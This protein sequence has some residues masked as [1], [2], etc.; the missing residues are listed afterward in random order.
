MKLRLRFWKKEPTQNEDALD[1]LTMPTEEVKTNKKFKFSKSIE[2]PDIPVSEQEKRQEIEAKFLQTQPKS[3]KGKLKKIFQ[4][5]FLIALCV[6]S[7]V[8]LLNIGDGNNTMPFSEVMKDAKMGWLVW[9]FFGFIVLVAI[10][11][12]RFS[13]LTKLTTKKF[14]PVLNCKVSVIGKY[15]DNVTPL[16]TGGQPFQMYYYNKKGIPAGVASSIPLV[17]YFI[18]MFVTLLISLLLIIFNSKVLG[19]VDSDSAVSTTIHV[20]AY[21]GVVLGALMPTLIILMSVKPKVGKAIVSNLLKLFKKLRIVK[22]Y[23]KSYYKTMKTVNEYRTSLKYV[24]SKKLY[25]AAIAGLTVLEYIA[26]GT[27]PFFVCVALGGIPPSASVWFTIVTLY[28]FVTNAVSFIP[29]P[30]NSGFAE[31]SFFLVFAGLSMTG[32][33]LFWIVLFWRIITY[34]LYILIGMLI[35][36]YDFVANTIREKII[37]RK[38]LQ[39]TKD[40]I[41]P[42]LNSWDYNQRIA[43]LNVL[44]N[45]E[46][47]DKWFTP[48]PRE[49][50]IKLFLKSN[51]SSV[52]YSPS[53]LAYKCYENGS[54]LLGIC[55]SETLSGAKEFYEACNILGMECSL[56]FQVKS[57]IIKPKLNRRINNMYQS[58]VVNL[59]LLGIPLE[60]IDYANN[61]LSKLRIAESNR[62]SKMT[63]LINKSYKKI[64]VSIDYKKD[65]L[66]I[67]N[68][69][70]GGTVT[71]MHVLLALCNQ[72]VNRFGKSQNLVDVLRVQMNV[73]ISEKSRKHLSDAVDEVSFVYDL[74]NVLKNEIRTFYVDADKEC[75]NIADLRKLATDC[76]AI[77][78]YEYMGDIE[79]IVFGENRIEVYEDAVLDFLLKE[80]KRLGVMAVTVSPSR[81]TAEQ[82]QHVIELCKEL[83]LMLIIGETVYT[84]RQDVKYE[85]V[86]NVKYNNLIEAS[87]AI[88][89]NEK[90]I[91]KGMGGIFSKSATEKYPDLDKRIAAFA[92]LSK[93]NSKHEHSEEPII[94]KTTVLS[95]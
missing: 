80:L 69:R 76:Q 59:S 14:K 60:K 39:N 81:H 72:L 94:P 52:P 34:Y 49:G 20:F 93:S 30:G 57:D 1:F 11:T 28:A 64:G 78:T 45:I 24:A 12:F 46:N 23:Q 53:A 26:L 95:E 35:I 47:S 32:G 40:T 41:V 33:T 9:A 10:D 31:S 37:Q 68:E 36:F 54:K 48:K 17:K 85:E 42:G 91:A 84:R 44:K 43:T 15:Y 87:R 2:E 61:F 82:T 38:K 92:G 86:D 89:Y 77:L 22:D 5:V 65:I 7:I 25:I 83:E 79:N 66:P 90:A 70:E 75:C 74:Q 50:D 27:I 18:A 58:D 51:Y 56:G 16:A 71:E 3:R 55:D 6:M 29:T 13:L 62:M 88:C 19:K 63:D 73:P 8:L 4:I 67:S 21:V